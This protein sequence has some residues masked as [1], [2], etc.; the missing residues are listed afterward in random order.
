MQ[1]LAAKFLPP[2]QQK[3]KFSA[4]FDLHLE[5]ASPSNCSNIFVDA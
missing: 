1:V 3:Q 5:N 4:S 2:Q